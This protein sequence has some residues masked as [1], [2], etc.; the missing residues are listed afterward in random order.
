MSL[1]ELLILLVIA[2]IC[3]SIGQGIAGYSIG[4]W[5]ISIGVG[6]IGALVGKWLAVELGLSYMLPINIDGETFP[7][8]W[9]IIGSTLFAVVVGM[10]TRKR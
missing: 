9:S 6:L 10:I 8:V 7:I 5:L 1:I 3:G 4:G 2:A